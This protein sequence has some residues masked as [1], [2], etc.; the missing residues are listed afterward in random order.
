MA[1]V[2]GLIRAVKASQNC[3]C[4]ICNVSL[5]WE[6]L[7]RAL[8]GGSLRRPPTSHAT[9]QSRPC[10]VLTCVDHGVIWATEAELLL[11]SIVLRARK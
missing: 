1:G 7:L 3:H 6:V 2:G 11:G 5:T 4:T 10:L 9:L 8:L